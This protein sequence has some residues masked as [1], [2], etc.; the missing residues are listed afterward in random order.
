MEKM[1]VKALHTYMRDCVCP[2]SYLC[3]HLYVYVYICSVCVSKSYS[4]CSPTSLPSRQGDMRTE[5]SASHPPSSSS[6][7]PPTAGPIA[8]QP[9]TRSS[10]LGMEKTIPRCSKRMATAIQK[11]EGWGRNESDVR[12]G[13]CKMVLSSGY[14]S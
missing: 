2:G 10:C 9:V 11:N 1:C 12:R 5:P 7:S 8:K 6:S 3:V 13:R 14:L 4:T